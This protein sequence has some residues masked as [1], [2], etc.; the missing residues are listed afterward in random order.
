MQGRHATLTALLLAA[1]AGCT[2]APLGSEPGPDDALLAQVAALG[3]RTDMVEVFEDHVLVEGDIYITRAELRSVRLPGADPLGP[4]FQYSTN[5]LVGRPKINEIRVDLAGLA[6]QPAWQTAAREALSHWSG[7]TDSYVRMVEG[8]PAD[9][10][11]GTACTSS[12]VAAYASFPSGGN[13]GSTVHVNV[14]FGYSTTHA[15]KVHNMVHEFGHT[16][17]FRH[18]NFTQM[19][20]T[21]GTVGANHI[22]PTPTS[23]NATGSVMNG[24]TALH[25]WA[26]FVTSDLTAVR[27][28]Y[29]LPAPGG[30]SVADQGGVPLVSWSAVAGA[31]SYT[32]SLI[33]FSTV[34]G[35]YQSH[36]RSPITTTTSTSYLD[37][38]NVYTGVYECNYDWGWNGESHGAWYEYSVQANF[39]GGSS[40]YLHSR[41]YAPVAQPYCLW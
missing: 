27:A 30:L 7:I 5:S 35:Q 4:R 12:N 28:L 40:N 17:G 34:N 6:S 1:V 37:V 25:S 22:W 41:H 9:I 31:T 24:G 18:S 33:T 20:E 19:G 26:G 11:V 15:Q 32:V 23:G 13:P 16:I 21:A 39:P 3:F 38:N 36:W 2:D 14:C 29:P 8:T 10:T